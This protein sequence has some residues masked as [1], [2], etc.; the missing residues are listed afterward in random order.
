MGTCE[1]DAPNAENVTDVVVLD[2]VLQHLC[3]VAWSGDQKV[4]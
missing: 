1:A 2:E 3:E 4:V